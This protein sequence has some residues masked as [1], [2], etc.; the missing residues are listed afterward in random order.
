MNSGADGVHKRSSRAENRRFRKQ[1]EGR[2]APEGVRRKASIEKQKEKPLPKR[3]GKGRNHQKRG[4]VA[5]FFH[6]DRLGC[7]VSENDGA[8]NV[9][10]CAY[11]VGKTSC[12]SV[13]RPGGVDDFP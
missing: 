7:G 10:S 8:P 12:E 4:L 5:P 13:S 11:G 6:D 9:V 2:G 3:F 1:A